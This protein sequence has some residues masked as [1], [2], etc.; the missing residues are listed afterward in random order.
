MISY[1]GII[2]VSTAG[3]ILYLGYINVKRRQLHQR[4]DALKKHLD[5]YIKI[6]E[7]KN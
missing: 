1:L 5:D 6:T 4:L 7:D 3:G 2:L